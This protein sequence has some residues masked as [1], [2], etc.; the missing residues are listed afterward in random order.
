MKKNLAICAV[1]GLL[2]SPQLFA[3]VIHVPA[4]LPTIQAGIDAA[5]SGDTV[6]V[7]TGHY[8]E[9]ISFKGKSI[10]VASRFLIEEDP[11]LIDATIIDGSQENGNPVEDDTASVVRFVSNEGPASMLAGF[12]LLGG[13]GT[14]GPHG[15]RRK[16]GG[17]ICSLASP[18]IKFNIVRNNTAFDGGG[19]YLFQ[20]A[21]EVERNIIANNWAMWG[22]GVM[23]KRSEA[24]IV[25]NTIDG[26]TAVREGGGISV[27]GPEAPI[28]RNNI[29]SNNEGG[30]VHNAGADS[31]FI[32]YNDTY[33]NKGGRYAGSVL[34]GRGEIHCDPLFVNREAGDYSLQ[35]LSPAIDAGSL[36]FTE[37]PPHGGD[38]IDI[39]A[40]EYLYDVTC[41]FM[42]FF[43]TPTQG[44]PCD[45]VYWD[46]KLT[47]RTDSTQVYDVWI[48]VSGPKCVL[49]D[50]I[51]DLSFPPHTT[52]YA[53]VSLFI[54]C[55]APPGLYVAKGKVGTFDEFAFTAEAFEGEVLEGL[56]LE[57]EK[58]M[59][60][61]D[62]WWVSIELGGRPISDR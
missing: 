14:L 40:W 9:R 19:I 6:L 12:T 21:A 32:D 16:G 3:T 31:L 36:E 11:F 41:E 35:V 47:N 48:D 4:D 13:E 25:N 18:T 45:T 59:A 28:V 60:Y 42:K 1:L 46:V 55:C 61:E 20:S 24:L 49:W 51:F 27:A 22:G 10:L 7:D 33:N 37:I 23:A 29:I 52:R 56:P 62:D 43:N 39:G 58:T 26:N 5:E 44:F 53:T 50:Y 8:F 57:R 38:R 34:E 54:P 15:T 17:I 2:G 30:G